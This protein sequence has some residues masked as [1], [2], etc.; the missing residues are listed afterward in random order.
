[1][2]FLC[3]FVLCCKDLGYE[4]FTDE[5]RNLC[6]L[7]EKEKKNFFSFPISPLQVSI[8][9]KHTL[10]NHIWTQSSAPWHTRKLKEETR[11]C[12]YWKTGWKS[13]T[14]WWK[15]RC[16]TAVWVSWMCCGCPQAGPSRSTPSAECCCPQDRP[17]PW[18]CHELSRCQTRWSGGCKERAELLCSVRIILSLRKGPY[19]S[20]EV[21]LTTSS[22]HISIKYLLA[23]QTKKNEGLG[24]SKH[25]RVQTHQSL[26]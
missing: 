6:P 7:N 24:S 20:H 17:R 19:P 9:A 22:L 10:P 3:S 1:M 12:T 14:C 21:V 5:N 25:S 15:S 11:I 18:G 23:Y 13:R 2:F 16:R 4:P 26:V 8:Y